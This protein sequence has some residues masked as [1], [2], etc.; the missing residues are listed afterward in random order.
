DVRADRRA[1]PKKADPSRP[2]R[3]A[4]ETTES[5]GGTMSVHAAPVVDVASQERVSKMVTEFLEARCPLTYTWDYET[6]RK[7]LRALYEKAK[8]EQWDGKTYLDWSQD[9]DPRAENMPDQQIAIY[10][11]HLWAK[12]SKKNIEDLRQHFQAW[13]LS[14]FMHGEQG[15]LLAT[16]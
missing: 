4:R 1:R 12:L 8:G 3:R 16:A 6:S 2:A 10:G 15:A 5:S 11:T 14:Q 13:T 9:V 7:D